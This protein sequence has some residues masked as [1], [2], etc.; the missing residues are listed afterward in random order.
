MKKII[1]F[2]L[3][4]FLFSGCDS[5]I[6]T[7]T[8]ASPSP[9]TTPSLYG[10]NS[11]SIIV[12]SYPGAGLSSINRVTFETVGLGNSL[13][14]SAATSLLS[15]KGAEDYYVPFNGKASLS[16]IAVSRNVAKIYISGDFSGLTGREYFCSIVS[17]A[18]TV[19]ELEGIEYMK[20]YI[21][22]ED[23]RPLGIFTN[24]LVHM[25]GDLYTL[26][27]KHQDYM[28]NNIDISTNI[29]TKNLLYFTDLSGKFLLAEVRSGN[30]SG[31]NKALDLLNQLKSGPSSS[32]EMKGTIPKNL[33]LQSE[34]QVHEDPENGTV[35]TISLE[36]PKHE[37]IDNAAR[38]TLA[39]SIVSTM[40]SNIPEIDAVR[41]YINSQPAISTSLMKEKRF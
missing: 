2:L 40:Q 28:T 5:R 19:T 8:T 21:N 38:Y 34:P 12:L 13:A 26:Y 15:G 35:L 31:E 39:A 23:F 29:D 22:G 27:L 10:E 11:K 14:Y 9:T 20:L 37:A 30:Q 36:V 4:I 18:N 3:L 7:P 16:K 41:L 25:D 32:D 6:D 17:L 24:P 1:I 33:I